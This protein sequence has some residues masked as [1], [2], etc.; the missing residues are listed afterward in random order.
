MN[1]FLSVKY[2]KYVCHN[3]TMVFISVLVIF[4]TGIIPRKKEEVNAEVREAAIR[5]LRKTR[6]G[7]NEQQYR[8]CLEDLKTVVKN[9]EGPG[10]LK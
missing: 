6:Q 5:Q 1:S 7:Q 3:Q 8:E 9:A 2:S 4:V 10:V